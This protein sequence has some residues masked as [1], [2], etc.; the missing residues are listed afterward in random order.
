MSE[1]KQK[2]ACFFKS[3]CGQIFNKLTLR[4][5]LFGLASVAIKLISFAVF[6]YG[7]H[8]E[9]VTANAIA[10]IIFTGFSYYTCRKYVFKSDCHGAKKVAGESSKFI[11][12]KIVSLLL[13]EG[14]MALLVYV[15]FK[16]L[17]DPSTVSQIIVVTVSSVFNYT[18]NRLLVFKQKWYQPEQ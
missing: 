10:W 1:K 2:A 14:L 5:F 3:A 11:L 8:I 18:V 15:A 13:E 4:Y 16:H 17:K 12:F 7:F 9:D 6:R